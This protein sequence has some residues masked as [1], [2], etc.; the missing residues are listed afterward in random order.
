MPEAFK[1]AV[2]HK[3]YSDLARGIVV[4]SAPAVVRR[5]EGRADFND[6]CRFAVVGKPGVFHFRLP[7]DQIAGPKF[8]FFQIERPHLFQGFGVAGVL[9]DGQ[10]GVAIALTLS[11]F[12]R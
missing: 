5:S 1:S 4:I 9:A 10:T 2:V 8:V 3:G 11:N 6:N 12:S 7:H